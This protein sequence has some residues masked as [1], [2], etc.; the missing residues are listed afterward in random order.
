MKIVDGEIYV[1][2]R[3]R[4][5]R[6]KDLLNG[7]GETDF[8]ESFFADTDVSDVPVQAFNVS[9][10]TDSKGNFY[11]AKAGQYTN[12][13]EPGN[14]VRVAPDAS[15]QTSI[16][17]GFRAPNGGTVGPG[18]RIFVSDN[19]GTWMGRRGRPARGNRDPL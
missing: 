17:T 19:Q 11:Y 3:D 8:Y 2:C 6:L 5:G 15:K 14:L 4:T 9:L 13:D 16:A 1:M 18:D 10:D 12:N 7:D